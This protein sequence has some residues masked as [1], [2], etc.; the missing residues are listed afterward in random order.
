MLPT[1]LPPDL[2]ADGALKTVFVNNRATAKRL[3]KSKLVV[4]EGP[5]KGAELV[6]S[7]EQVVVGRSSVCDLALTDKSV[8]SLH[9]RITAVDNGYVLRDEGSTNG[10]FYGDI[11][12]REIYLKPG[13][14]FRAGNS[15]MKFQ[16]TQDILTI[17]LS[18]RDRFDKVIGASVPMREIFANLERVAPSELTVMIQGETGTGK[19]VVAR[20]VHNASP[21]SKKPFVVLD[22]SAIPKD[23]IESTVFGHE[24]GAFTGAISSHKGVFEQA[25]GGTIFLDELGELPLDMQPKLLRVLENREVKRVGSDRTVNVDVRVVAATNRDLRQMVTEGKFREDLYFR[26][27]VVQLHLPPLRSR[28]DDVPLLAKSFL[29]RINAQRAEIGRSPLE[30]SPEAYAALKTRPWPGNVRELKNVV[31]RAAS[32]GEGPVLTRQ[33]FLIGSEPGGLIRGSTLHPTPF[34]GSEG[35]SGGEGNDITVDIDIDVSFKDAKQAI[36]D[37][38]EG[39]YLRKLI[40]RHSGNISQSAKS[41]GL[42]RYHLR[43]LLKKHNIHTRSSN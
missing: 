43:E 33:D 5:D 20:A 7:Q 8:S 38:F 40:E 23:L 36:L 12:I 26:M 4:L 24:K 3:R 1:N 34:S 13:T 22:C 6:M 39:V 16:P 30:V 14:I 32:L 37:E 42:T 15:V 18:E 9:F 28:K 27:S 41:A 17:A 31:E 21:R 11:K 2:G 19:E 25:H 35:G 10:T 29:E